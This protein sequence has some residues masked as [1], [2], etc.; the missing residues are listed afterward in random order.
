MLERVHELNQVREREASEAG[1]VFV[2]IKNGIGINTGRCTV[3][4]M[5]SD[6]RFQ[7]TVMGDTVNLASRLEG[8]TRTY[9]LSNIIGSRTAAAAAS[10]FALLEIDTVRVKGKA[11][12][13]IVFTIV[14]RGEVAKSPEFKSL[15]DAWGAVRVCYRKQDW[16][17][18]LKMIEACRS[19]C[20]RFGL[21][22]LA[23]TYT[24]RIRRLQQSPPGA[25]WDGVFT[26]E[27]K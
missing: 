19:N 15:Q 12:P 8:Q 16:A 9:G 2:P 25:D 13:E 22:G 20:G 10:E 3:G 21:A 14:G 11:E 1:A 24:D 17:G 27:T 5:G 18:A 7:Y 6:L 23:D 26:A 4:N